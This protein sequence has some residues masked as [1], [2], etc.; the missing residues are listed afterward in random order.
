MEPGMAE[1][2]AALSVDAWAVPWVFYLA[3]LK[4]VQRDALRAVRSDSLVV[5]M[6]VTLAAYWVAL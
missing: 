5:L 1:L 4:V 6:A 3:V 2:K